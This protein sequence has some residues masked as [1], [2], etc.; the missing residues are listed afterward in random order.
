MQ[1]EMQLIRTIA[2][3]RALRDTARRAGRRVGFVP[4]M[5]ALHAGHLALAA[6]A[7]AECE[8]AV[9]SI[10]V[11]PTQFND[12][13][14]LEAYPRTEASD[15]AQLAQVGVD[16]IFAPSAVEMYPDGFA[17]SIDVGPIAEP[18][19]GATR[20]AV[21]FRG[22]ATV[23]AKLLNIIQPDRAYFGQK[24]AQQVLVITRLVRDLDL[25][26]EIVT[27]PTVREPDGLALSSR[28][29]RL[30]PDA[31][32][33]ALGLSA[34]LFRMRDD[35]MSGARR[36]EVLQATGFDVLSHH[37]ILSEHVDYLA[38]VDRNTLAPL[39]VVEDGA[40]IA[41]AAHVDGVRL[42]DNIVLERT[43]HTPVIAAP[44]AADHS[45]F[46]S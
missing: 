25:P 3:W 24:D 34:A 18:L 1:L 30:S 2:E 14:D 20:G 19:E 46:A 21:H 7:R 32:H 22:V 37:G 42:I 15:A 16:V 6:Q 17:T 38:V 33:R 27:C 23:V 41:I 44:I 45:P 5:G 28:N 36:A 35:A 39:E 8:M 26:V 9:A 40:L 10:F 4:T 12:A 11:N 31:R 13:R 29:A 43:D